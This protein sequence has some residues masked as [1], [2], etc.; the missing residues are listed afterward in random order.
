MRLTHGFPG[1][2]CIVSCTLALTKPCTYRCNVSPV[3]LLMCLKLGSST[4]TKRHSTG[5]RPW[6]FHRTRKARTGCYWT[7]QSEL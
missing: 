3:L 4:F 2:S 6:L 7:S 5:V 1:K